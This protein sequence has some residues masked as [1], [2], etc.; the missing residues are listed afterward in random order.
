MVP[1]KPIA[2]IRKTPDPWDRHCPSRA[3]VDLLADKWVLLLFPVLAK[4]TR[5]HAELMRLLDGVSQKMLTETLRKLEDHGLVIRRDYKTVPPKV[6]YRL[7]DLGKSL[8]K[9]IAALDRW[10][11]DH[12]Y[13]VANARQ[14]GKRIGHPSASR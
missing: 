1:I 10:V 9:T 7:S 8:A 4:E 14:R 2:D 13:D 11:I 5:R 3:L 12:Y 6:D